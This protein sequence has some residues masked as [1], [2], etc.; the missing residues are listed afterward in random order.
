MLLTKK[1]FIV[2]I[3]YWTFIADCKVSS[4]NEYETNIKFYVWNGQG[5][6]IISDWQNNQTL[7]DYCGP[8][9]SFTILVHGW[10]ESVA[11][12]WVSGMVS[13]F[14]AARGGC[15]FFMDYS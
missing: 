6:S 7:L 11:A 12:P 9:G 14:L 4:D 5:P 3:F 10:R 15:V 8:M 1:Y 2:F 13:N